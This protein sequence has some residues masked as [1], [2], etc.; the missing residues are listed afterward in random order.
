MDQR[1]NPTS[2][3]TSSSLLD[4]VRSRVN[5]KMRDYASYRF[6]GPQSCAINIFFD[7]AQEFEEPEQIH[8]L[9]VLVLQMF[10][11]YE[12][13]LY[14]KNDSGALVLMTPPVSPDKDFTPELRPDIWSDERHC[15]IPVR[16]K[17][18]FVPDAPGVT[19][20]TPHSDSLPGAQPDSLHDTQHITQLDG[21]DESVLL[22]VLVLHVNKT[23]DG[24]DLLF[25]EKFANRVG[26]CLHNK[27]L[28]QRNERHIIFLRKLAHDIGHNIVTPNMRIKLMISQL[29]G[30][31]ESLSHLMEGP[32][33][34]VMVHDIRVLQTKM[35]EHTKGIMGNFKNS[36]L[37]LESLLRQGH[38]D[39]GHYVLRR[40]R[41]DLNGLIVV[42]QCERFR[43]LLEERGLVRQE[44]LPSFPVQP[45]MVD[46]D[47][48]LI[49]QVLAN[50]LS[51]AVKYARPLHSGALGEVRCTATVQPDIFGPG[52]PGVRV[53]VFSSGQHIPEGEAEHLFDD[54]FRA[55]NSGGQHGTGHG[56][57]FVREII[58]EHKGI[59]GYEPAKGGNVFFFILPLME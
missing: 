58:S 46:A 16:D 19:P 18:A 48:G 20:G 35:A 41:I 12:A 31:I 17:T 23:F 44:S 37:F 13:E 30:Q 40:S 25:L 57:F 6:T 36:A 15:S 38:F 53:T 43:P 50:M 9:A 39:F 29:Q 4:S 33:D 47:L 1:N 51:N 28:A 32:P 10:F 11:H 8:A 24:H 22:G 34:D 26:F 42:P 49:S 14:L 56:L 2:I 55:S 7:L 27:I 45:F 5:L 54:N 52:K 21:P 59:V 3:H